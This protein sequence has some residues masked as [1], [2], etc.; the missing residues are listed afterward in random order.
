MALKTRGYAHRVDVAAAPAKVWATLCGPTLLPLWV[1]SDARI[2]PYK[3]GQWSATIA[4]GLHRDAVIDLFEPPRRLRLLYLSPPELPVFDGAVVDDVLLEGD[5]PGT[6]VRL[7]CSG[8]PDLPEWTAYYGKV[9]MLSERSLARLK[10]LCE[11]R[12]RTAQ[13][14]GGAGT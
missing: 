11:M 3:G 7:L 10:V 5:G 12:E 4:P 8:M 1:G 13:V 6:I 9:R 2:R 14:S